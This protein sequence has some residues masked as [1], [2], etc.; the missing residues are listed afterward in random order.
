MGRIML[1]RHGQAQAEGPD[2]DR[3]SPLG[4]RQSGL[5][6]QWAART[7][8]RAGRM[9]CGTMARHRATQSHFATALA[10]PPSPHPVGIDDGFDEFD[11]E[12][13]IARHRPDLPDFPAIV[14]FLKPLDHPGCVFQD[15]F[16]AALAQWMTAPAAAGYRES[17]PV[18]RRRC[19][20]GLT[21]LIADPGPA[22]I[23]TVFTSGGPIAAICQHVL[24]L[25]DRHAARLNQVL[26]NTGVT[27]L[28]FGPGRLSLEAFNQAAHLEW[29]G[30]TG[31]IT[32][33]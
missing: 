24:D 19:I 13:V 3:L 11:F 2:Y 1:V 12:D 31:L 10:G 16:D 28:R 23:V 17:W 30:E 18:F 25:D 8:C 32:L 14:A 29:P 7:G 22:G 4:I 20:D 15:M 21:R 9:V 26:V 33:R 27:R 6:G 5:L